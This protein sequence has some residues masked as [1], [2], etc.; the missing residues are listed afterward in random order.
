MITFDYFNLSESDL[1]FLRNDLISF[2][3]FLNLRSFSSG[4]NFE[5]F[6]LL[7]A[8]T[9]ATHTGHGIFLNGMLL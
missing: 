2:D 9:R 5:K 3:I 6:T 8:V 1:T 4:Y 7:D